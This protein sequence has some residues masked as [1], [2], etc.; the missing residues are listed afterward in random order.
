MINST[1][2]WLVMERN[3]ADQ[4]TDH[5]DTVLIRPTAIEQKVVS[6]GTAEEEFEKAL[7]HE[8]EKKTDNKWQRS[9]DH[10]RHSGFGRQGLAAL[11]EGNALANQVLQVLR[12]STKLPP[13][14]A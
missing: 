1:R 9:Q 3:S 13:V 5:E 12:V 8:R 14:W 4:L 11:G 7:L 6:G 2:S 10:R